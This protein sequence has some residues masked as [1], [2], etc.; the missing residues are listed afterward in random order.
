MDVYQII[1]NLLLVYLDVGTLRLQ[2]LCH[3]KLLPAGRLPLLLVELLDLF[4]VGHVLLKSQI[5]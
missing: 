4:Q 3:D 5:Q 2:Q 1:D